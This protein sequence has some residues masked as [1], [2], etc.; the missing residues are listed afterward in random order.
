MNKIARYIIIITVTVFFAL[1]IWYFKNIV[2]YILISSILALIGRPVVDFLGKIKIGKL[3]FP[4]ALCAGI[5]LVLIW[6]MFFLFFRFYIPIIAEQ[7]NELSKTNVQSVI[8][9]LQQPISLIERYWQKLNIGADSQTTF[10]QFIS[11]KL[12]SALNIGMFSSLFSSMTGFLESIL[13]AIFSISFITFFF[14]KNPTL[15]ND[16]IILFVPEKLEEPITKVLQSIRKLL[17]RYFLGMALDISFVMIMLT[18]GLTIA[19]IGFNHA[20]VIALF[21]GI[22]NVIPYVG[23]IIGAS[24]GIFM[25]VVTHLNYDYTTQLL[26]LVYYTIIVFAVVNLIDSIFTQPLIYS[27]SVKAHPLE[28][29]LVISIAGSIAGMTG[30]LL[31]IPT[32]T[33]VR[34]FAKE[35]FNNFKLVKK[36]TENI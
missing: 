7:A 16:G 23:P 17:T 13:V 34:V 28:I 5:T 36:L 8:T 32:Y 2:A 19:G 14:L 31:A 3:K 15:F 26:P 4:K 21:A 29:F 25:G 22:C 24:F 27:S 30:M 18:I 12:G 9:N 20:L 11:T 33:I 6:M 1:V 35:F 10:Q